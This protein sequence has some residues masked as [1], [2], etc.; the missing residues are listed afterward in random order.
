MCEKSKI[1]AKIYLGICVYVVKNI[2]KRQIL[3]Y[4]K[5]YVNFIRPQKRGYETILFCCI[6][7]T[8][9]LKN[10][11]LQ[12]NGEMFMNDEFLALGL[13]TE[14]YDAIKEQGFTVPT[15][16]QKKSIPVALEGKDVIGLSSTGSG[17]TLA[18]VTP[19]LSQISSERDVQALI[20]CPTRELAEQILLE[21]R[22][23]AK[24]LPYIR[25]VAVFGGA[26]IQRQIYSLKRG[27]NIVVGTP[28]RLKDHIARRT[29]RLDDV[30]FVVLDEADEMLNMGFRP[31][32]EFILGLTP[33]TRQ[34]LM[35]SA[36]MSPDILAITKKFMHDPQKISVGVQNATISTV[37]QTYYIVPKE[38]KKRALSALLNE[39]PR[40]RTIIFCN[41]KV[42]VDSVQQYLKKIGYQAL[43]LHGDMPQSHRRQTLREFKESEGGL[44]VTTD[45]AARGIDVQDILHVINFDLPQNKEY[46]VHRVGRTGRAGKSGYAWT[47]LNTKQQIADLHEIEKKTNS[48]IVLGTLTINGSTTA[49]KTDSPHKKPVGHKLNVKSRERRGI[50][51]RTNEKTMYKPTARQ[52]FNSNTG[53]V[54]QDNKSSVR[55]N[56]TTKKSRVV[57]LGGAK[58][59]TKA[60]TIRNTQKSK[61]RSI[62]Y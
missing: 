11:N 33:Q 5:T 30:K 27:A 32:M 45:V 39:L 6:K 12:Q 13:K 22:K 37:K 28:G 38:K 54:K 26:D 1:Q 10:K 29:L 4:T 35:F 58:R 36:T 2:A 62:H 48:K 9:F 41:T 61:K 49:T 44:I 18:Y 60:H 40:G 19:I 17:K 53:F 8:M 51:G 52:K 3:W 24:N 55:S 7:F 20:M 47:L 50:I 16:I 46:Y 59:G 31:D 34:T 15:E 25:A 42:M 21:V 43:A 14:V 56:S 57:L 23:Y